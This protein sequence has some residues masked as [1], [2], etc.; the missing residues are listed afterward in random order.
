MSR[1]LYGA[2]VQGIQEFIFKTNKLQDVGASEILKSIEEK[3]N[4]DYKPVSI[5]RNAGGSIKAIFDEDE[6][7]KIVKDFPK[8]I[9]QKAYG[10]TISQAVVKMEGEF[11]TIQAASNEIESRLRIQRNKPTTPLDATINLMKLSPKTARATIDYEKAKSK[12]EKP[13]PVDKAT[14]QK[15]RAYKKFEDENPRIKE[16]K[17]FSYIAN[18]KNKLAIIHADG[19]GLGELI[20]NL[21]DKLAEFSI[22]LETATKKAFEDARGDD[23][24]IRDIILGGDDMSVV[25]SANDALPFIQKFLAN[26]EKE[27]KKIDVIKDKGLTACAGIAYCNEKY[28]FHYAIGLAEELCSEAKKESERKYSCIMFHNI[29]SSNFQSWDKYVQDELTIRN[30]KQEIDQSFAPYYLNAQKP[31]IEDLMIVVESYRQEGSPISRLRE[32][33]GELHKSD[34]YAANLL[35]RINDMGV[36][37]EGWDSNIMDNNLAKLDAR[38]SSC[39]LLVEVGERLKTP[40][41]DVLQILSTTEVQR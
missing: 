24:S 11:E 9:Q 2:S 16:F 31:L 8:S 29:Q 27:T 37:K 38:L 17:D 15:L 25:C 1:Y 30:D 14:R 41:Y 28:P 33:L 32:W 12:N 35:K 18:K 6:C 10:I 26:F 4:D 22:A 36:S 19:N 21:G 5:V 13:Q 40:I 20:P 3:F 34:Q 7:R 39:N 23:M